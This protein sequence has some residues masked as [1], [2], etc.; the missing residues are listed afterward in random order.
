MKIRQVVAVLSLAVLAACSEA[1]AERAT[2]VEEAGEINLV[3]YWE[4]T[5]EL[6]GKPLYLQFTQDGEVKHNRSYKV[7]QTTWMFL[8]KSK[9]IVLTTSPNDLQHKCEVVIDENDLRLNDAG[10]LPG[11]SDVSDINGRQI[12]YSRQ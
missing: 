7:G 4:S 3:G 2:K 9:Q 8:A 12:Y 10:C 11:Y 6:Q 5:T 1:D